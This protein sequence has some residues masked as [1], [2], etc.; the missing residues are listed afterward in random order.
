[1]RRTGLLAVP[2]LLALLALYAGAQDGQPKPPPSPSIPGAELPPLPTGTS[3]APTPSPPPTL[4]D[5]LKA[6]TIDSLLGKLNA[7]KAQQAE[8]AR[9]ERETVAV[10]KEK[11]QEQKQQ[12]RQLGVGVEEAA[13]QVVPEPT[14]PDTKK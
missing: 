14:R 7:L 1:M 8:L 6:E 9:V 5:Q 11:L 3:P 2:C 4:R 12:L 10:L 13:P